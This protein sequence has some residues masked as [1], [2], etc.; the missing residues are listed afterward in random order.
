MLLS[1]VM[2]TPNE[3]W[4]VRW[5]HYVQG[6]CALLES[7]SNEMSLSKVMGDLSEYSNVRQNRQNECLFM[8]F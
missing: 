1:S 6:L 7:I 5:V 3:Y 2:G 4:N 8:K